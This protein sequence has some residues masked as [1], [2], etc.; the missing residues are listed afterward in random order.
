MW[1]AIKQP[2]GLGREE[3]MGMAGDVVTEGK[4]GS[5]IVKEVNNEADP[6]AK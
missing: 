1:F 4:L 6:A 2:G 5:A 3:T